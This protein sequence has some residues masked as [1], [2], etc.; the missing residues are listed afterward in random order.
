M[1]RRKSPLLFVMGIIVL[2]GALT[3]CHTNKALTFKV[4]TGDDI[5]VSL[6]TTDGYSLTN[7]DSTIIVTKEDESIFQGSFLTMDMYAAYEDSIRWTEDVKIMK[8]GT[9]YEN[10][11]IYF[12]FE[13]QAGMENTF[14][15][16]VHDSKTGIILASLSSAEEAEKVFALLNFEKAE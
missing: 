3:A 6:D 12:Q 9:L 8:E 10:E 4:E 15:V 7:E 2:M 5:V 1:K 16:K 13:G 11:Y 14:L